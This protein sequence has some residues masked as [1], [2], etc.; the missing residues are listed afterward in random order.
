[1]EEKGI[2]AFNQEKTKR[3]K[4]QMAQQIR[5]QLARAGLT[6]TEGQKAYRRRKRQRKR[7][8]DSHY[9]EVNLEVL[10]FQDAYKCIIC[11][12]VL[13]RPMRLSCN[14]YV[15]EHCLHKNIL[16]NLE[17]N[18]FSYS[19][20]FTCPAC[21]QLILSRPVSC[22]TVWETILLLAIKLWPRSQLRTHIRLNQ[23]F[24]NK[25]VLVNEEKINWFLLLHSNW[26][27]QLL[28]DDVPIKSIDKE[29]DAVVNYKLTGM[30]N[31]G[32]IYKYDY[33]SPFKSETL[34]T[35]VLKIKDAKIND[36][37]LIIGTMCVPRITDI[38][39][40]LNKENGCADPECVYCYKIHL[41]IASAK[42]DDGV[43]FDISREYIID[44]KK[45]SIDTA[46]INIAFK[47]PIF[48]AHNIE[49]QVDEITYFLLKPRHH[50]QI[51][52]C[53]VSVAACATRNTIDNILKQLSAKL[54]LQDPKS[55]LL[56]NLLSQSPP[57]LQP[58]N[59]ENDEL[60]NQTLIDMREETRLA[61]RP[62]I[63]DT[64]NN[65]HS[66]TNRLNDLSLIVSRS[67]ERDTQDMPIADQ[68]R[69]ISTTMDRHSHVD[70]I[71]RE[72][73]E[74]LRTTRQ[75]GSTSLED[76]D[77]DSSSD[78][79]DEFYS[80]TSSI[81]NH[82][83]TARNIANRND[84]IRGSFGVRIIDQIAQ[85]ATIQTQPIIPLNTSST[86]TSMDSIQEHIA[87]ITRDLEELE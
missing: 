82:S 75:Y 55:S 8:E 6:T 10:K 20:E 12:S 65:I 84:I 2:R 18:N 61:I 58:R 54:I 21:R 1:M 28:K 69:H 87:G 79:D 53:Y 83:I 11:W 42:W 47:G 40:V 19:R 63:G 32:P 24:W 85:N 38:R 14:H 76:T 59:Y 86:V 78:T 50:L 43:I 30:P 37:P 80:T 36:F 49:K 45:V 51:C 13:Y 39:K 67:G 31:K 48:G 29:V 3:I 5:R 16:T 44:I 52:Y 22:F 26:R 56:P 77:S 41:P 71:L 9:M 25:H 81:Q 17:D 64:E 73:A 68:I 66:I 4:Q 7:G 34:D 60:L 23:K 46:F 62:S 15:C 57:N 35:Y 74:F 27:R 70:R 33:E 72:T